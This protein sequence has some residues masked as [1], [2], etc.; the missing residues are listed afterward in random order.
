M[1]KLFSHTTLFAECRESGLSLWQCPPF[2]FIVMGLVNIG[3]IILT[4]IVANRYEDQPE[5][6]AL[7]TLF[8]AAV[9]FIIGNAIIFGFNKIVE[10]NAREAEFI[11]IISH[12]LRSPLSIFKWTLGSLESDV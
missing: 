9:I 6:T 4:Y 5:I 10:A 3:S 7:L 8:V 11:G 12:Q 1:K 2:L